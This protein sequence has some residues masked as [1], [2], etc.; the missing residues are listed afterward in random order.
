MRNP[1]PPQSVLTKVLTP[2][3]IDLGE[4]GG[5]N[6]TYCVFL[7]ISVLDCT[8][9]YL[10]MTAEIFLIFQ[11]PFFSLP[12]PK[13]VRRSD[14]PQG[15]KRSDIPNIGRSKDENMEENNK[16]YRN[17]LL[18]ELDDL[19]SRKSTIPRPR[20]ETIG[21]L[22]Q[23]NEQNRIEEVSIEK[24]S[25]AR[26]PHRHNKKT[27]HLFKKVQVQEEETGEP[28]VQINAG[29]EKAPIE[30]QGGEDCSGVVLNWKLT[31]YGGA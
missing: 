3:N 10:L 28:R 13:G 25:R 22:L 7:N 30:C 31:L 4:G 20:G 11:D 19:I 21:R 1:P 15:V 8:F 6:S 24:N 5:A 14:I 27:S 23:V 12:Y 9:E 17:E 29:Y 2:S 18:E 16:D 26:I